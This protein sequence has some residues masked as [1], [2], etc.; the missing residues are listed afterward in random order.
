M[1]PS[2]VLFTRYLLRQRLIAVVIAFIV[3]AITNVTVILASAGQTGAVGII[4]LVII[5]SVWFFPLY[6]SVITIMNYFTYKKELSQ[7]ENERE[8]FDKM[9]NQLVRELVLKNGIK[10]SIFIDKKTDSE[11]F[12]LVINEELKFQRKKIELLKGN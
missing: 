5:I 8:L 2:Q 4:L 6:L 11:K 7:L 10:I 12:N 3:C 1:K 9:T